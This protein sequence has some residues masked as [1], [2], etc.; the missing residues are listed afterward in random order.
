VA[1]G[2]YG[3]KKRLSYG[4]I[5]IRG[6][7][8]FP[9]TK[10]AKSCSSNSAGG[11]MKSVQRMF[12]RGAVLLASVM[13]FT[14]WL[15]GADAA[16][17]ADVFPQRG[18]ASTVD[19]VAFSP[20]GKY[21]LS[22]SDVVRLWNLESG[23]EIRSFIGHTDAVLSVAF[24]PDGMF[25]LSGSIDNTVRLWDVITGENIRTFIG[26]KKE[27]FS[28]AFSPD[29]RFVLSGS[30]DKSLRI[31]DVA[32]G[33]KLRSFA[34]HTNSIRS[35]AF[36]PDGRFVLSGSED[37]NLCLW[38]VATGERIRLYKAHTASI[39]SVA[40]S[41]D[42]RF[43]LSGSKDKTIRLWEVATGKEIRSFLGH[44]YWVS[45]VAFSPDGKFA[46]SCS[47][48]KTMRFWDVATGKEIHIVNFPITVNSVAFSP[49][50][51]F[52]LS[53][54]V[55]K[56]N[57]HLWDVSTGRELRS[58]TGYSADVSSIALSSDGRFALTGSSTFDDSDNKLFLWDLAT[59][60]R[61]RSFAG[62]IGPV[63]S[64]A[65]SPDGKLALSGQD[66]TLH[67]WD[68]K[69][70]KEI[71]SFPIHEG[72]VN[73]VAF[74]PDGRF[75]LSGSKGKSLRLWNVETGEEIWYVEHK[76]TIKSVAF[77]PDGKFILSGGG[78]KFLSLWDVATGKEIRSFAGYT[79][80]VHSVA[81]SPDGRFALSGGE[82]NTVRLWDVITGENI[83]TFIGHKKEVFSVAFSPDGMFVLSG[84]RD[85]SLRIWDV[86]T[87]KVIRE[88]AANPNLNTFAVFSPDGRFV[89]SGH[90]SSTLIQDINTG[91]ELVQFISF[92][93]DEWITI[94]PEGFFNSSENGDKHLNVR[95]DNNVYGIEQYREKFYR[96]DIVKLALSGK[97]IEG[98][99]NIANVKQAPRVSI[100]NTPTR[101]TRDEV[102]VNL[103]I[104]DIGGGIGDIRLYLNGSAVVLDSSRGVK[105]TAKDDGQSVQESYTVKLV[106]G[107]NSIRAIAFNAE[108]SMQ[109]TDVSLNITATFEAISKHSLHAI[110]IGIDE[111]KNPKLNL[112]YAVTDAKLFADTL[113]T[114][115]SSLFET[116]NITTL[117]TKEATTADNISKELKALRSMRPDDLF[118]FYVASH[119][120]VDDGEYFLITSNVGLT[121]TEKL[122]TDAITQT[123][124]KELI[125]NIPTTKKLILL[126]TCN[127]GAAGD[128]IQ[129]AMLTRGM[130]ED[131]A[132]KILSRAVGSTILSAATSAQEALEGY[133]G[134]GLFTWVLSEGLG[135]KADKGKSGYIK[136]TDLADYVG[137]EVPDLADK[138]FKRAQYPTISISGQA[139]PIGQVR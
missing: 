1:D 81:F 16:E 132:M 68:I 78:D 55:G 46:V 76:K 13:L 79:G 112:R 66:T 111:Y 20:D 23:K 125:A 26:H 31:W 6:L 130:S 27:V 136:T 65:F 67:L 14:V 85:K 73:S 107:E 9:L 135:G 109:S 57:L 58:F 10:G 127:A 53:G 129:V 30:R 102:K 32:T 35:V 28:V 96:P 15:A 5:Y 92:T 95:I 22:G 37:E 51:R 117:T 113:K 43:A 126:D 18:H 101:V 47:L 49:N 21:A 69:T 70:G 119:G 75:G 128:A 11:M 139:F 99:D 124:L 83:R 88:F 121:R 77:S 82:D 89:L 61:I 71:R 3:S 137:D 2:E 138:V 72:W 118:V 134:H 56:T 87:G 63:Y 41:P 24:S 19:S 48:D 74:S 52:I 91:S 97:K 133:K 38:D 114:A 34:G 33:K 45:S 108:N 17:K 104:T 131:T 93:D 98:L 39:Y 8:L 12:E 84:S 94:T 59:G 115:A 7:V 42:G 123:N 40:F 120:V 103:K 122:K 4:T 100:V 90:D 36:S 60:R 54:S 110:V 29:G 62:H 25:A 105:I 80:W 106:N 64:L 116:V 44:E 50:G 86:A